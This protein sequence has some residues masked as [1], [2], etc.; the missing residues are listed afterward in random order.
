MK[1]TRTSIHLKRIKLFARHG[2]LPQERNTGAYFYIDLSLDTD[3]SAAARTDCLDGTVSYADVFTAVREEMNTPSALLEH[4][5]HRILTRL[6]AEFPTVTR[7]RL[8]LTK[9]NPPMGAECDGAGVDI[10]AER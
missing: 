9:E 3:F 4:A 6:F 2:V 8:S 7:I 10:T 5:A 1:L